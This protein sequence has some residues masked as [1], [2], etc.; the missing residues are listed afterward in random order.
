MDKTFQFSIERNDFPNIVFH[1]PDELFQTQY[2]TDHSSSV[3][4]INKPEIQRVR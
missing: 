1:L 2:S 3:F 4:N